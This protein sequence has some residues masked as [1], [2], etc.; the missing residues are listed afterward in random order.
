VKLL[1]ETG[2]LHLSDWTAT[3]LLTQVLWGALFCLPLG[4]SFTALR[5]STL[6]LGWIGVLAT[7]GILREAKA[8]PRVALLGS[9]VIALNPI[10][11]ACAHSFNSDVPSF[12]FAMT[13]AYLLLRGLRLDSTACLAFGILSS[14]IA[15]MNRQSCLLVLLAFGV[16][17]LVKRG[18]NERTLALALLPGASGLALNSAYSTWLVRRG[19]L[20][21]LFGNQI[22]LLLDTLSAGLGHTASVFAQN[23]PAMTV[24]VGLFLFPFLIAVFLAFRSN[25][26]SQRRWLASAV[27]LLGLVAGIAFTHA[28][29]P[30]PYAGNVLTAFGVGPVTLNGYVARLDARSLELLRRAWMNLSILG[31]AGGIVLLALLSS[32]AIDAVRW[33]RHDRSDRPWAVIFHFAV[34]GGYF[35]AIGGLGTSFWFDRYLIFPLPMLM[36]ICVLAVDKPPKLQTS[37]GIAALSGVW[38]LLAGAFAVAATHDYLAWNRARWRAIDR[39]MK[40]HAVPSTRIDGGLEFNGWYFGFR[41][42]TCNPEFREFPGVSHNWLAFTCLVDPSSRDANRV[43][44]MAFVPK[45]GFS[46]VDRSSFRRWLPW[47][48]QDLFV[49][50]RVE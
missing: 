35:A 23:L 2:Q 36:A 22:T 7:F 43:Y 30:M 47:S 25:F 20:P 8:S 15:V 17:V 39:L 13:S 10:Y 14:L 26:P 19:E 18:S 49:L 46:V 16:A 41:L 45:A 1:I 38:L 27:A 21:W 37:A 9:L 50:K 6:V 40:E 24:Y 12:A 4:F 31:A 48:R 44:Q 28:H 5:V 42:K 32:A 33:R 29:G 11:V 34:A 3:N